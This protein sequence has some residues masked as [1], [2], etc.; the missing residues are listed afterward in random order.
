MTPSVMVPNPKDMPGNISE[1]EIR[2]RPKDLKTAVEDK[3]VYWKVTAHEENSKRTEPKTGIKPYDTNSQL[4]EFADRVVTCS[5]EFVER[6]SSIILVCGVAGGDRFTVEVGTDGENYPLK[7][8]VENWRKLWYETV[9]PA[10]SG[11][12]RVSDYTVF[13][14][15]KSPGLSEKSVSYMK[16]VLDPCFVEFEKR[17]GTNYTK[18][19]IPLNGQ[20]NII[21]GAF[22]GKEKGKKAVVLSFDQAEKILEQKGKHLKDARTASAV[23]CDYL[24]DFK[25]WEDGFEEVFSAQE[26]PL[27]ESKL[28]LNLVDRF[29]GRA[30]GSCSIT[31]LS[32]KATHWF[33]TKDNSW[34]II[35]SSRDPGWGHR[36]GGVFTREDDIKAHIS[37]TNYNTISFQFPD[38]KGNYPGK[39]ME[40]DSSGQLTDK[41]FVV[42]LTVVVSGIANEM[43]TNGAALNGIIWMNTFAG[44]ATDT[45]AAGVILHELG[46]NMGQVYANKSIDAVFG[47]PAN[48]A[49]PGIPF[50][51]GLPEGIVYGERGHRGTHCA[52]GLSVI[53]RKERDFQDRDSNSYKERNCIMFGSS[54]MRS[55]KEYVFCSDCR[56]Y[57]KAENLSDIRKS[58]TR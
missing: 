10:A 17:Y 3:L 19:D 26:R 51:K 31:S 37:F 36:S 33:D 22:I 27:K 28:F 44:A 2:V 38:T 25:N 23:W 14:A 43:N 12:D 35:A 50:P 8:V 34:K 4:R 39:L 9:Q 21:D 53:T 15:D 18:N 45:G 47:R 16:K 13:T 55:N 6:D 46:H 7:V 11:S 58:W 42:G 48:K 29:G 24:V 41:R 56:T 49:I 30:H 52:S 32:W 5:T 40:K 20:Y 1:T 57:V 54:S